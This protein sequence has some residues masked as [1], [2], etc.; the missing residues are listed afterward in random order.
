MALATL[1]T[2]GS[3]GLNI[4][5]GIK[6]VLSVLLLLATVSIGQAQDVLYKY[7][8]DG[9]TSRVSG[10]ISGF[11]P[12]GV[13]IDGNEVPAADIKKV[14][15]TREPS[16]IERARGQMD[17]RRYADSIAELDK[18]TGSLSKDAQMEVE[19]IRAFSS[20]Q[21]SLRGGAITPKVA[22]G[23]VKKF[24]T[25]YGNSFHLVPAI[26]QFAKLAFA[27]GLPQVAEAEF[28]KL[29]NS[30]WPEYQLKG[31]FQAGEMQIL[32]NKLPDAKASFEAILQIGA[33]DDLTQTYKLLAK[34]EL[35][36]VAGLQ[37]DA[38]AQKAIEKII[39]DENP[40]DKKLFAHLYNAL[41]SIHEKAGRFKEA[42][43]A[44][45]HTELLF[46]SEPE[47][48]AEALYHLALLWPKLDKTD[49]ANRARDTI[50]SRYRNSYWAGQL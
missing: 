33:N 34:C 12:N 31:Y 2:N 49:R 47:A 42:A 30:N 36:R 44:Y 21:I 14:V 37:G 13:T 5:Q 45:L 8:S 19:F 6:I 20:A 16:E 17:S 39:K 48:H 23:Q 35:A 11:T 28:Q 3:V 25:D 32:L 1:N 10:K 18:I 38:N 41:G 43:R 29:Q 50:K 7:R 27:A 4:G 26:D 15:F 22:A 46:A 9:K 40:D 24:I